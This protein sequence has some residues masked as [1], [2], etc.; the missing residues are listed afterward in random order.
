MADKLD[1]LDN[2]TANTMISMFETGPDL[3]R[4]PARSRNSVCQTGPIPEQKAPKVDRLRNKNR[5][6]HKYPIM[7]TTLI[8]KVFRTWAGKRNKS[9]RP[10]LGR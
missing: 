6:M 2:L 8:R 4:Q 3:F 1:Y 5:I 10:D 7:Y 9:G